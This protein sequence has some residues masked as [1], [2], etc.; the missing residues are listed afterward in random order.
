MKNTMLKI[1][2]LSLIIII[3]IQDL[4]GQSK[5]I[6]L[7]SFDKVIV[8]PHIEAVFRKGEKESVTINELKVP[9]EK[10]N[11]E[12]EKNTLH[13]F[14]EGAKITTKTKVIKE[15]G[16]K[17]KEPIYKGTQAKIIITYK[18]VDVYSLRGE[19]KFELE[20]V[21]EQNKVK[22]NIYGASQT[23][24]NELNVDDLR[25]TIYGESFL[26]IKKGNIDRQ[27]FTAYGE[28]KINTLGVVNNTT[29]ITAYGDGDYRF[30]V[31]D[32]LKVT[33]YG[34]AEVGYKGSPKIKKGLII[35]NTT[36]KSIE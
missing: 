7:N 6:Q 36:I 35:G 13:I 32:L 20:G 18:N 5:T 22:F 28:S 3:G 16:Y 4:L 29:K 33:A 9:M 31:T 30:N 25:V 8:S 27:K 1:M 24:I 26:E 21:V 34:E 12:V 19:E 15:N 2:I 23:L 11:I 14:L 17:K 10:L